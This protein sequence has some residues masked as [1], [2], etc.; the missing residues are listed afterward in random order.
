MATCDMVAIYFGDKAG[1]INSKDVAD[2]KEDRIDL[3]G[4]NI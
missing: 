4:L 1:L 2:A 3:R